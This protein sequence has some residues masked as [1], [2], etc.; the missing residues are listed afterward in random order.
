MGQLITADHSNEPSIGQNAWSV[1][2]RA[3]SSSPFATAMMC[4]E[5]A[6]SS[7]AT[8]TRVGRSSPAGFG[9]AVARGKP[10]CLAGTAGGKR[11]PGNIS[12]TEFLPNIAACPVHPDN[13]NA[14]R[15][16][17]VTTTLFRLPGHV[18]QIGFIFFIFHAPVRCTSSPL[19]AWNRDPNC[20]RETTTYRRVVSERNEGRLCE[21]YYRGVTS[22]AAV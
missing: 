17:T 15:T 4:S 11:S 13:I 20:A 6:R 5:T 2:L 18:G 12:A 9:H 10:S 7:S 3:C 21:V 1:V 19:R 16:R 22:N 8:S 14:E